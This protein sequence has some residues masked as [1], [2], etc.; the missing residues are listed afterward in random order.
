[1]CN[2]YSYIFCGEIE[3]VFKVG[4]YENSSLMTNTNTHFS[5]NIHVQE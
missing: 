2:A 5:Q 1:M 3:S 4:I